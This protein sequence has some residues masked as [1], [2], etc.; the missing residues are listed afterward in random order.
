MAPGDMSP[1]EEVEEEE[2][3]AAKGDAW[4]FLFIEP[5]KI[6]PREMASALA[7]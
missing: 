5:P 1:L 4:P 6:A 2:V 3:L 7:S